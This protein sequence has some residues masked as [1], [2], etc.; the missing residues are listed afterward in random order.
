VKTNKAL[1][2]LLVQWQLCTAAN[3]KGD[4]ECRRPKCKRCNRGRDWKRKARR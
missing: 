1:A 4:E 3:P 2:S